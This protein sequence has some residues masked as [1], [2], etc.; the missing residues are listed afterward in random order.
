MSPLARTAP[1][2]ALLSVIAAA[3]GESGSSHE[4]TSVGTEASTATSGPPTT[5]GNWFAY[6]DEV[7]GFQQIFLVRADGGER[8]QLAPGIGADHQTNPDWSPAGD[9]LVFAAGNGSTDDLWTIGVDGTDATKVLECIDPCVALDDPAWSPDGGSIV[10]TRLAIDTTGTRGVGTLERLDLSTGDA[11]VLSAA[12]PSDFYAGVRIAPAG[13]TAVLELVHTDGSAPFEVVNG[14]ELAIVDL[15]D[16]SSGI[17]PIT[18][19]QLFG[20][21]AD[22]SPDGTSIVFA[23]L[24]SIDSTATDLFSIHPDGSGLTR[25]TSLASNG[26]SAEHPDYL[27]DGTVVFVGSA[28]G[29]F[30]GLVAL[31]RSDGSVGDAI[32]DGDFPGLHPRSSPRP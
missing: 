24:A 14:V 29:R 1:L 9:R 20:A 17:R 30:R 15:V 13:D 12:P 4:P 8:H 2:L 3:C 22:W 31:D 19:A 28:D 10:F 18:D 11:S 6:Q 5:N 21:T 16:D 25:L 27:D 32:A 26:G 23:A 7:G